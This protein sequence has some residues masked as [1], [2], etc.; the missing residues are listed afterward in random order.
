MHT[1]HIPFG[2][3]VIFTGGFEHAGTAGTGERCLAV[4][5]KSMPVGIPIPNVVADCH[6]KAK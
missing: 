4:H 6:G 2:Y 5:W 3:A 1:L